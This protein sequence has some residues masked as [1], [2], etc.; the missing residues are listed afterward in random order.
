MSGIED[1]KL[2][3]HSG[4]LWIII[5]LIL[6]IPLYCQ[7]YHALLSPA[8]YLYRQYSMVLEGRPS[9]DKE[10]YLAKEEVALQKDPEEQFK[11]E[12]LR[13]AKEQ[14]AMVAEDG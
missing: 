11:M 6:L 1:V 7:T 9:A 2:A 10:A 5:A 8:E 4:G 13:R 12:V 3:W 14:Y